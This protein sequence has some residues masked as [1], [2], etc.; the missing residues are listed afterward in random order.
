MFFHNLEKELSGIFNIAV[1]C[2]VDSHCQRSIA[3]SSSNNMNVSYTM[4][5]ACFTLLLCNPGNILSCDL[6]TFPL[7][8]QCL[9][10]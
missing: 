4:L 5:L 9:K 1:T 2:V 3:T 7:K 10:K 6:F 8:N